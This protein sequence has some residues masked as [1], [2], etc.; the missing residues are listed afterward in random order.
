MTHVTKRKY[1]EKELL[2][3]FVLPENDQFIVMVKHTRGNNLH[4]VWDTEGEEFLVSMPPKFRNHFYIKKGM[5]L[6]VEP[7]AEG[8]KVKAEIIR[9]L[10]KEQINYIKSMGKWPEAFAKY[11]VVKKDESQIPADM[12]PPSDSD[13]DAEDLGCMVNNYNRYIYPAHIPVSD[14]EEE[15]EEEDDDDEEEE[16]D[17]EESEGHNSGVEIIAELSDDKCDNKVD[18]KATTC[19]SGGDN[20]S[21]TSQQIENLCSKISEINAS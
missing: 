9:I 17:G 2:Y 14:S 7:I 11:V 3:E 18:T 6:I 8:I 19:C 12:L 20:N 15:E 16:N 5:F 21:D 13:S 1:V 4:E 10:Y